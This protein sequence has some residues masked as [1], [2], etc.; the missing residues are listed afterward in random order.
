[1]QCATNT[2]LRKAF[3]EVFSISTVSHL[4]LF[5]FLVNVILN[6]DKGLYTESQNS[7]HASKLLRKEHMPSRAH[8]HRR[9]LYHSQEM[10]LAGPLLCMQGLN[11]HLVSAA[12]LAFN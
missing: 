8:R 3:K 2:L 4:T 9:V 11:S 10:L 7:E 12:L 5:F 6:M 1:M